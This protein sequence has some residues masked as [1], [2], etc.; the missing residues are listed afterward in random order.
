MNLQPCGTTGAYQRHIRSGEETCP[1][2]REASAEY[3]RQRFANSP[4][5]KERQRKVVAARTRAT[6]RLTHMHPVDFRALYNEEVDALDAEE[7]S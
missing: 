1:E 7:V 6:K 4:K 2:C 3:H 5:L